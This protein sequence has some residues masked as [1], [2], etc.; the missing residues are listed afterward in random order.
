M[1]LSG[2]IIDQ[3]IFNLRRIALTRATKKAPFIFL[4][5]LKKRSMRYY[6]LSITCLFLSLLIA[7]SNSFGQVVNIGSGSYTK[8]FPGT[9]VAGR[10]TYP[11]GTPF[12]TG[13]AA[14]KPTPT[15]DWWSHKV[16]N[17]HSD[18]LFNYP[19][20][21]KTVNSGLVISYIPWGVIDNIEPVI[22]GVT[23]LNAASAKVADFTDWTVA[24]DWTSGANNFQ[25]TAGIGM[26]FVYFT[27]SSSDVAQVTVNQGTVTI[28]NEM[29]I[30]V[31]ARNSA[32]FAV[33][34]PTGSV[35]T[36]S[37]NTY[38]STLNGKN[39]W[40][41]GFI[42]LNATNVTTTANA[43]KKYAYVFP[44]DTK[45]DWSYNEATSVVT[46]DF[47]IETEVKE[48]TDSTMLIG[49]LPHQ[50]ANLAPSAP[51]LSAYTYNTVR[52]T[53]K[54]LDGNSFTVENTFYGILPTLPYLDY[55]SNGFSP[56]KLNDKIKLLENDGLN[57]WTDSYN[58]GQEMNRL[59]QTARIAELSGDTI[60]LQKL[61]ITVK[62]RLEDWLKYS[63]GEVA[64]L[65]YYNQ[66][67]SAMI[68]YPA[69]HG[70]D[71]NINDHHFHWG[72]FI[73]AAS[74]VE[75]FEPGWA[76]QWGDMINLLVRDAASTDRQDNLFPFLRNFSPY[77]GHCW[78]NGFA[79]FPQGND[80]E[81]TS[82]SMQFNSSLIHWG[83]VTGNDSI[84]NLGIYLYTTEQS[85]V[86]EYWF[87]KYQRNFSSSQQ[88][89]LV[90]RV[91]GNSYDNGTFWTTD[92]AA[93]YGIELYPI[94]GG[95]MYLGHDTNYVHQ[96]WNEIELNTGILNNVPNVNLWHDIMW[97]YLAFVNPQKAINLYDSYPNRSLKFGVSDAQTYHWLHGMNVLGNVD[98][99]V[100]ANH[101]LAVAFNKN[102]AKTYVGQNYGTDS[103]S[104][105][106]SDGYVLQVPPRTLATSKDIALAGVL[107]SS[108]LEAY[109]GGSVD[110]TA[111]VSGG[112]ATKVEFYDDG[113]LV[114]QTTTSP[115]V[116]TASNLSVGKHNLYARVYN[117]SSFNITNIVT[118]IVGEQR[119]YLGA[120]IV[121]PGVFEAG[122]YDV[123]DGGVGN[124]I[125]YQDASMVNEGNFRTGEYV[126]A[127]TNTSEGA[128]VGWIVGGEWLEYTV[129]VQ[130]AGNYNLTFRYA[131]GNSAGG[132]PMDIESDGQIIKTG[133]A[134]SSTGGWNSWANKTVNSI[135]L[136]SGEQVL[137]LY[138][139]NGELNIGRFT[140]T[141]ASPL[142]YSQPMADA[143]ANQIVVLPQNTAALDGSAST[144][145]NGGTLTYTW[146]QVYGPTTLSFSNHQTAQPTISSLAQGVYLL[147]LKVSNGSYS[148]EDQVYIISSLTANVAPT[149]SLLSPLSN[150][151][152][153]EDQIIDISALAS[154]LNDSI[155]MVK[156]Y[157]NGSLITT[158]NQAPYTTTWTSSPG[159]YTL[160]AVAFDY[161][162]ASTTS[163]AVTVEFTAAPPC[164]GTSWNGDFDYK[165]SDADNNPTLTFISNQPG[166]GTP[167]CILYYGT[168][169]SSMPGYNVTRN[170]PFQLNAAEGTLI[171]F[172]YT[173]S[174]PGVVEKNNADH[175]DTY[176]IGSCKSV[177]VH[178]FET[179]DLKYFPNPV[180]DILNIELP[181]GENAIAV[182]DIA[183]RLIYTT[184]VSDNLFK[185]DMSAFACGMYFITVV[186]EDKKAVLKVVK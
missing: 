118:V 14:T 119:P 66:T 56:A 93:S 52:G 72:Y 77:A 7:T 65:F 16:K 30:I 88:Y 113:N 34:A 161:N 164:D 185:Y 112:T 116:V 130:Q 87:D 144:D 167:T 2:Y 108:F 67:W 78:A 171:Y 146:T 165:F 182:H 43:Y 89:S 135:P 41:L 33:Y 127:E 124:G 17:S 110:L 131:C 104:V 85:A 173:Y 150:S 35:W 20:T 141:Y 44:T 140:F 21:M 115:F 186:N 132:G 159:I 145:P 149:V 23:G 147:K 46:T 37:G 101:P 169:P 180:T 162:N 137:R 86:E 95:S 26:P 61:L 92:I 69:G 139:Q 11:S 142:T 175:K 10:N 27:K 51:T 24:M 90:S 105:T 123:F 177:S 128:T 143:G 28:A 83:E 8:S 157:S 38:T 148:D 172:Y 158:V 45:A 53:L 155:Q 36:K 76:S 184:T 22:V 1:L 168:N 82:E 121:I 120:L 174:Y 84:R 179:M 181:M 49:L 163:N 63:S 75:Q 114:G 73:H 81:S 183:G 176:V 57:S 55:Y 125:A 47:T 32:D 50:W 129:D 136:K 4:R 74:F 3:C 166:V 96:L 5:P 18:N 58:E 39:Y 70:Q 134:V 154:D 103:I 68:G 25:A 59:I 42:P 126:D 91:W 122:H 107:S 62:T 111:T 99:S 80:Q 6:C 156:F 13:I 160:T 98:V 48:G 117:G 15:N 29:L 106:F 9:D 102:G 60:A 40:S 64:F 170:V 54:M 71:G 152:Y 79:S 133:I 31:D 100:T 151:E 138:F 19:F 153:I 97:E 178:H 12:T 109:P 94:H